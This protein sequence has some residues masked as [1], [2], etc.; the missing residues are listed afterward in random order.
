MISIPSEYLY[1]KKTDVSRFLALL[2]IVN[3]G[4]C[5]QIQTLIESVI[6]V[7]NNIQNFVLKHSN[8]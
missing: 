5:L 8:Q 2:H 1:S 6:Q 7:E 4:D 3:K